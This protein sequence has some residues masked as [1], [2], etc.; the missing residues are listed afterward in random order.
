MVTLEETKAFLRL[1][2]DHEDTLVT[3]FIKAAEDIVE[4]V[5]RFPLSDFTVDEGVLPEIVKTTIWYVVSQF[6]EFRE[7]VDVKKL[8]ETSALLLTA[9][10]NKEW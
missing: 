1:D 4:G 8:Q 3:S 10:R 7:N 6:Y 9:Y 5:L 2:S